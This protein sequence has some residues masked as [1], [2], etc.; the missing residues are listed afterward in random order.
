[1]S[2]PIAEIYGIVILVSYIACALDQIYVLLLVV[3]D[4]L[5]LLSRWPF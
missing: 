1:M 4:S 2:I 5:A 3:L